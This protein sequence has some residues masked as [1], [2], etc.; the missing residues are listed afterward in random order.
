MYQ[1]KV[2]EEIT[3]IL[4]PIFFFDNHGKI[5]QARIDHRQQ[6]TT[7]HALFIPDFYGKDTDAN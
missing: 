2:V 7:E 5:L 1:T 3:H 6:Y 4:G